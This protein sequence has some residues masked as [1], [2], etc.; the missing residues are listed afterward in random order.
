MIELTDNQLEC[1][2]DRGYIQYVEDE[3]PGVIPAQT[4]V[5]KYIGK[6]FRTT[7]QSS[8]IEGE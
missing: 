1:L 2:F 5:I 4:H 8:A 7:N 6:K 3:M